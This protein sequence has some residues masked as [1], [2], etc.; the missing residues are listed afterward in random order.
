MD[1]M[2]RS[3]SKAELK[4]MPSVFVQS[5]KQARREMGEEGCSEGEN[6]DPNQASQMSAM[7]SAV[8]KKGD[9][10][11]LEVNAANANLNCLKRN[12]RAAQVHLNSQTQEFL[13]NSREMHQE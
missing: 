11:N 10:V 3:Y 12:V 6:R 9:G 13:A 8:Q 1:R 7:G 5:V 2:H 4:A